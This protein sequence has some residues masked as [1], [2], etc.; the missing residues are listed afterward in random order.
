VAVVSVTRDEVLRL[1]R[2]CRQRAARVQSDASRN[3]YLK[4]AAAWERMAREA[5][6]RDAAAGGAVAEARQGR[7][8]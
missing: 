4:V 5:F 2:E 8:A 1:A 3:T 6:E 7:R